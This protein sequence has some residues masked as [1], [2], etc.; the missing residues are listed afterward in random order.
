MDRLLSRN[1]RGDSFSS[2]KGVAKKNGRWEERP[3]G[4]IVNI[5]SIVGQANWCKRTRLGPSDGKG[6]ELHSL[7]QTILPWSW[8]KRWQSE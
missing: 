7:T 8:G 3:A 2:R 1:H 5:G 6:R 4:S